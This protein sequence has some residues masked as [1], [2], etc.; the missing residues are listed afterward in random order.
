M[1][2]K[3]ADS[4]SELH[5]DVVVLGGG[6]AG[7]WCRWAAERAGL[8]V[9]LIESQR[10]GAGQTILAQGIVHRGV[11]YAISPSASEA[12]QAAD[13]AASIWR[14]AMGRGPAVS[15]ATPNLRSV[16]VLA[17][18]MLM[19]SDA[20]LLSRGV[21]F[22]ASKVLSSSVRPATPAEIPPVLRSAGTVYHVDEAV[23]APRSLLRVLAE[24]G[25]GPLHHA[26]VDSIHVASDHVTIR[27]SALRVRAQCVVLAAGEGNADLLRLAGADESGSEAWMQ[28][29]P[30]HMAYV[31]NAPCELFGHW[32]GTISDKPR[33]T[34]TSDRVGDEIVWYLG[35]EVAESGV[36]F[37]E[38]EQQE[39]VR[40]ELAAC[41]PRMSWATAQIRT[42]RVNR[43]EGFQADGRRPDLPVVRSRDR[44]IAVWP[45]K[46]VLAP[47]AAA[48]VVR[49][50]QALGVVGGG[51]WRAGGF[52]V[53]PVDYAWSPWTPP[54]QS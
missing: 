2:A 3:P 6:V 40:R 44:L 17:D 13:R 45:T 33:L 51:A 48:E 9:L 12:A 19:W 29:R 37:G 1:N 4:L 52:D 28:R 20:G 32:I 53:N 26:A 39:R 8:R 10:M 21:A 16:R 49:A 23:V 7:L 41:F 50:V 18:S 35:G 38:A 36:A 25:S 14:A 24:Q 42:V 22:A 46:M 11:K 34:I 54:D 31:R 27:S 47:L 43:A 30:L 15:D 5:V